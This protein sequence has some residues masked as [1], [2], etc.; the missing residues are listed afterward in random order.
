[1]EEIK[2]G[3][4]RL[5]IFWAGLVLTAGIAGFVFAWCWRDLQGASVGVGMLDAPSWV[6]AI[7]SIGALATAFLVADVQRRN[8]RKEKA[9]QSADQLFA[10]SEVIQSC[11]SRLNQ[12]HG[13]FQGVDYARPILEARRFEAKLRTP[14][15]ALAAVPIHE[16]PF[17]FTSKHVIPALYHL[18]MC[19]DLINEIGT[20]DWPQETERLTS[21]HRRFAREQRSVHAC[22]QSA[23]KLIR[24]HIEKLE[25]DS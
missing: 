15:R 12:I 22:C 24:R 10:L 1:M 8:A 17:A 2:F 23:L 14:Y 21:L 3:D 9:D 18:E 25:R 13:A 4:W 16:T 6:Q 20:V 19:L 7:G 11:Q 5:T